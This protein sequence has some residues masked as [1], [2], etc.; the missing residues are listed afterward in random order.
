MLQATANIYFFRNA[1]L[2]FNE[3]VYNNKA[4]TRGRLTHAPTSPVENAPTSPELG[5]R[6]L[7]DVAH[8]ILVV[9]CIPL[10]SLVLMYISFGT[11]HCAPRDHQLTTLYTTQSIATF[12]YSEFIKSNKP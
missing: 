2:V 7:Q 12:L 3:I 9:T 6:D 5:G 10:L 8:C 11:V 4:H 1:M